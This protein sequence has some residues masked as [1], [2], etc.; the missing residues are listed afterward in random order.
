MARLPCAVGDWKREVAGP[1]RLKIERV[2]RQLRGAAFAEHVRGGPS[3]DPQ[4]L[5][6]K[7]KRK[8]KRMISFAGHVDSRP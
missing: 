6:V 8:K 1:G 2:A 5:K 7:S 3:F 4:C